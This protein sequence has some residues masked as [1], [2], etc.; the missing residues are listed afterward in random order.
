MAAV[1]MIEEVQALDRLDLEGLR[2]VWKRRYGSPPK[3]RAVELLRLILAWRIQAGEY[4][5]LDRT[6]RL[7]LRQTSLGAKG[8]RLSKGLTI[9]REWQGRR[10]E[11]ET[12]ADGFS[13]NGQ[14]Y[15]SL[16]AVARAITGTRW[17]G[18]RF[19][20]LRAEEM[21]RV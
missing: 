3:L 6:T 19:F 12:L 18:P 16:S 14:T 13:W 15:P 20:G 4:G 8:P 1:T 17:N 5:G 9:T 11:V 21:A 10:H 2:Q 7:A